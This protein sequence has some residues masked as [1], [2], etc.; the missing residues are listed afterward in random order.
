M[1]RFLNR[2]SFGKPE[3]K[4]NLLSNNEA[5]ALLNDWV[6]NEKLIFH[7]RQVAHLMKT[8]AVLKENLSET[9]A[10]AWY[11][12][13]LLHD[14]DWEKFLD[15]HCSYIIEKL[16]ELNVDPA[17]IQCIASHGPAHFGFEPVTKMDKMIY[18]FDELSGFIH[19]VSLL[20]PTGYEGMEVKTVKKRLKTPSFAA[21]VSR[22]DIADAV[23]R[24]DI[25]LEELIEFIIANQLR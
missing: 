11:Q 7:M 3:N 5:E 18:A 17:V 4:G 2:T 1:S 10:E 12:A 19:A 15:M 22:E 25:S 20:R 6:K 24:I 14:A 23:S 16:E 21:Q 9:E 8:W 13:G